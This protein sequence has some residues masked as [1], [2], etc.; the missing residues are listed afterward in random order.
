MKAFFIS[1]FLFFLIRSSH[2]AG[3][4][5]PAGNKICPVSGD[6]ADAN[7]SVAYEGVKYSFCCKMCT[8][9]FKKNPRK[10]IEPM[11]QKEAAASTSGEHAGHAHG[12]AH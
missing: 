3:Q 10:Y 9:D 5:I 7:V 12:G 11:K 1:T 6:K 8:N 4:E 2:A